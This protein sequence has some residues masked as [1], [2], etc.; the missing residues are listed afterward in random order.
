MS[1]C[2][3]WQEAAAEPREACTVPE[4]CERGLRRAR[5][6]SEAFQRS[7]RPAFGNKSYRADMRAVLE[8]IFNETLIGGGWNNWKEVNGLKYLFCG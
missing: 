3:S 7:C 5:S 1:L 8:T 6:R 2:W 4:L